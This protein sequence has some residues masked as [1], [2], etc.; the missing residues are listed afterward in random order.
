MKIPNK[1]ELQHL[2]IHQI[3]TLKSLESFIYNPYSC[4]VIDTTLASNNP[5]IQKE[6]F[7]KNIKTNY[8]N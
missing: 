1:R 5:F 2:I 7:E 3:L 6:S 4:L 8:D